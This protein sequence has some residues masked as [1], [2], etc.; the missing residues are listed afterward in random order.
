MDIPKIEIPALRADDT[1][2]RSV[3]PAASAPVC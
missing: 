1:T 3:M 2:Q